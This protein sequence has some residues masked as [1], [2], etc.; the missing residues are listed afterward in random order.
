MVADQVLRL[1]RQGT[2][3]ETD[4]VLVHVASDGALA[5]DLK[6]IGTENESVFAVSCKVA[7]RSSG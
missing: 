1:P 2:S 7:I 4:F 3:T 6:L 5:L